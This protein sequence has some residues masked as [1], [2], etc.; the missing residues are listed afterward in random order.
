[1]HAQCVRLDVDLDPLELGA[2]SGLLWSRNGLRFAGIGE[3]FRIPIDRPGGAS[4]AQKTLTELSGP[5][6]VE[7]PGSGVV[8]FAALPFDPNMSGELIVPEVV[9]AAGPQGRRWVIAVGVDT[10]DAIARAEALVSDPASP[11]Q[12]T[13]YDL[14]SVETPQ[15]WRDEIVT[16]VRDRLAAGELQKVVLARELVLETDAPIDT[17]AVIRR[18]NQSFGTSILFA[19]DGFMGASPELLISRTDDI[20]RAHPLAGTAPR[21]SDPVHDAQLAAGLSAS[22]KNR[23][24]HRIT[25]DWLLDRLLPYASYVDAQ[26]EPAILTLSNVHHLATQVEGRL[27]TPAA[28][29]LEL[30][31]AL[32]P[33][34][35]VGGDPQA[36]ALAIIDSF[37]PGD[38]GL[39]AGPVGWVDGA[40]N[41]EF[42]VGLRGGHVSGDQVRIWAGVG[43][44]AD[45]DPEAELAE[46][47]SKFQAMLGALVR[48]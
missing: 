36:D 12:P 22:A 25:I 4:E 34:P 20:V 39:Y 9:V 8:A 48:P 28:S 5:D 32:H 41:G 6:N 1:M 17:A 33:T 44:V 10:A 45:S 26:P 47:R 27:S 37:E 46:T 21:S 3:A 19:V 18:L 35:A 14:R 42:A 16:P 38:R 40:G 2:R 7:L 29:V 15:F 13:R 43:V 31:A 11:P 30:V 24:E 23:E